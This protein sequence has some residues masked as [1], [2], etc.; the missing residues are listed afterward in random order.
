LRRRN[1]GRF[2]SFKVSK[3]QGFKVERLKGIG[4]TAIAVAFVSAP[5][6]R[7]VVGSR[8]NCPAQAKRGLERATS[9]VFLILKA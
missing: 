9:R 1:K 3:F 6:Q 7:F 2:Q 4:A 8:V 5:A